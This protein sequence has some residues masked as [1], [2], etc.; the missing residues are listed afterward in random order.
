M[1]M[2]RLIAL[3]FATTICAQVAS[4]ADLA[5]KAPPV[6]APVPVWTWA[7]WYVGVNLGYSAGDASLTENSGSPLASLAYLSNT[8]HVNLNGVIGGGQ[9]G[10]NWQTAPNWLVG[11]EADFQGSGQRS[12]ATFSSVFPGISMV[13]TVGVD[14]NWFGTV[15]GRVGYITDNTNLWYVTGGY[16]YG[17]TELNLTSSDFVFPANPAAGTLHKVDSGWTLGGGLESH[18]FG[19]WTGK[20]EYL[21]VDLGTITGTASSFLVAGLPPVT[22]ISVSAHVHDNIM[23]A[24]LNYKF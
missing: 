19:N 17:R 1:V 16:A 20:I 10:Y 2:S 3:L 9:I 22:Q 5:R 12:T 15:R 13:D 4:A 6:Q 23:R 18:L 7:G 21:Y 24:G 14:I 8:A 11:L